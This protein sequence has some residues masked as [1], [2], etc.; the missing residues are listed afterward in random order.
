VTFY[1]HPREINPDHPR[2]PLGWE[3]RF[4]TD[5]NLSSTEPKLRAIPGDFSVTTVRDHLIQHPVR[6]EAENARR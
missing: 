6:Q 4:R 5:V 3:R 2:L 1:V